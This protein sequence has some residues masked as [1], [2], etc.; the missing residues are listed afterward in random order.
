MPLKFWDE[1]FFIATFLTNFL[2]SKVINFET[3]VECLLQTTP[4]YESLRIFGCSCLPNL[5]P[6]NKRK[7]AYRSIWCVFLGYNPLHKGSK[8]LNVKT[9]RVYIPRDVVFDEYVYP[10]A[11]LHPNAGQRVSQDV[12][13]LPLPLSPTPSQLGDAHVVDPMAFPIIPIVTN[14]HVDAGNNVTSENIAATQLESAGSLEITTLQ[15]QK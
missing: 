4:N 12:L 11:S 9:G 7:L 1:A 14:D 8:C 13:I 10:F 6:Y 2:P 5:R 3:P 15:A